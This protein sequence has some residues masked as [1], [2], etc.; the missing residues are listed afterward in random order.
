[1]DSIKSINE[2]IVCNN[3]AV[4]FIAERH[5]TTP[6]NLLKAFLSENNAGSFLCKELENN[7][8]EIISGICRKYCNE[9]KQESE[10]KQ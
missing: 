6:E 7:E 5:N 4:K 9:N 10:N 1:M 3:E 2:E 8:L